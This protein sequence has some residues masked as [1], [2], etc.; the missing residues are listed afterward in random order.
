[1][2]VVDSA[3]GV[4]LLQGVYEHLAARGIAAPTPVGLQVMV[5]G[6]VPLGTW[7][8]SSCQPTLLPPTLHHRMAGQR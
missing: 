8:L 5:H 7:L 6:V 1:V 2:A 4:L 3:A